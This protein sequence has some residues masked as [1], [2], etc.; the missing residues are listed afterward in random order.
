[1]L[2]GGPSSGVALGGPARPWW[3]Q[4]AVFVVLGLVGL[5]VAVAV[6]AAARTAGTTAAEDILASRCYEEPGNEFTRLRE[7][8]CAGVHDLEVILTVQMLPGPY[9]SSDQFEAEV[10]ERC[11]PSFDEIDWEALPADADGGWFEPNRTGWEAGDHTIACYVYSDTGLI[12]RTPRL[13]G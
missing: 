8:D 11:G 2:P 6:F 9:P 13:G 5:L 12:G 1:M 7:Q 4:P 3:K 10:T